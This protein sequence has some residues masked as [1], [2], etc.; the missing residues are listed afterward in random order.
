MDFSGSLM[1]LD[2]RFLAS[3]FFDCWWVYRFFFDLFFIF[4]CRGSVSKGVN[5]VL[6]IDVKKKA[7]RWRSQLGQFMDVSC[8]EDGLILYGIRRIIVF[9]VVGAHA[10]GAKFGMKLFSKQS[11][12]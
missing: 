2:C 1:S 12:I 7:G 8:L 5:D 10:C 4:F 3:V 6:Q 9:L 11:Q